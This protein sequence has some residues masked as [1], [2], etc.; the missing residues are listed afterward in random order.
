[1]N[2]T[3]FRPIRL[4]CDLASPNSVLEHGQT[5]PPVLIRGA[6]VEFQLGLARNRTLFAEIS[7][8]IASLTLQVRESSDPS[9]TVLL[10]RSINEGFNDALTE[11]AFN[12]GTAEHCAIAF[13]AAECMIAAGDVWIAIWF[14]TAGGETIPVAFGELSV[15]ESGAGV[16]GT[17]AEPV[18]QYYT[19]TEAD[20]RFLLRSPE[21]AAFRF[22]RDI[23]GH[24]VF[25]LKNNTTGDYQT[26][27]IDGAEGAESIAIAAPES[28]LAANYR[29]KDG[30]FFQLKHRTS[31]KFHTVFLDG[32]EGAEGLAIAA[33][34][35]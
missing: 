23:A 5:Q 26:V 16:T 12:A 35:D 28:E 31:G 13:T 20:A 19:R 22:T 8:A 1:M 32:D 21:D 6:A 7:A 10:E 25:Q 15:K 34:E 9:S 29:V 18:E 33:G 30:E 17:P 24:A 11:S 4:L 14:T 2:L 27:F 3:T